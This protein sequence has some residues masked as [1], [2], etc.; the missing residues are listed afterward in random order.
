MT[1]TTDCSCGC[2]FGCGRQYSSD[3]NRERKKERD[4]KH[5]HELL[6]SVV[7][8]GEPCDLHNHRFATVTGE[9]ENISGICGHV[10]KVKFRTDF[11]EDHYHEFTGYTGGPIDVGCG[12]HVHFI[13]DETQVRE[14]HRHEFRAA[15]LIEDPIGEE[16]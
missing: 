10:H 8:A 7:I 3:E 11:Y 15:T 14:Q 2:D 9:A 12:R 6:G 4:Q 1:M 16:K 5:V 13:K